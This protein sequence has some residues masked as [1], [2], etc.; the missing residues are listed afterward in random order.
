MSQFAVHFINEPV[1]N[2]LLMTN[3]KLNFTRVINW[4]RRLMHLPSIFKAGK[5]TVYYHIDHDGGGT[6]FGQDFIKLFNYLN[7]RPTGRVLEWCGGPGFIG[8]RIYDSY[9]VDSLTFNDINPSLINNFHRTLK[10]IDYR[11]FHISSAT[12]TI[13]LNRSLI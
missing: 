9:D 13:G 5:I 3:L 4:I 12:L 6:S 2:K 7:F 11:I 10:K 8:F 1:S